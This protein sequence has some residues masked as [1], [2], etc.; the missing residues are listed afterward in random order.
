MPQIVVLP[1]EQHN[2]E[3]FPSIKLQSHSWPARILE[4]PLSEFFSQVPDDDWV[5]LINGRASLDAGMTASVEACIASGN[6]MSPPPAVIFADSMADGEL[7]I[8]P[9]FNSMTA[10]SLPSM[11]P[12]LA[13]RGDVARLL[14]DPD[15]APGSPPESDEFVWDLGL[16]AAD[17]AR[18]RTGS[19]RGT[20]HLPFVATAYETPESLAEDRVRALLERHRLRRER[21]DERKYT[22]LELRLH[23]R[24]AER[25][26]GRVTLPVHYVRPR[27]EQVSPLVSIIIPTIGTNRL[28]IQAIRSL[29]ATIHH[30]A[31]EVVLVTGPAMPSE[32]TDE[33]L[34]FDHVSA[35][36]VEGAFNF[37]ASVNTGVASSR[38]PV[39]LLLNDDV[40]A[41]NAGWLETLVAALNLPRV[42]VVGARLVL[43]DGHI[44]HAGI[45][46]RWDTGEPGHVGWGVPA[47]SALA[48]SLDSVL[49]AQVGTLGV[50]AACLA[51]TREVWDAVGGF[52]EELPGNYNDVVFASRVADLGLASVCCNQ[53]TLVHCESASRDA[54]VKQFEV[55]A[56]QKVLPFLRTDPFT[57]AWG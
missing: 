18:A 10:A 32:I 54:T 23:P 21:L 5:V 31:Y 35:V 14:A 26:D 55:D 47:D 27:N 44:Q 28:V 37:S 30:T 52:P 24:D 19:D 51:V 3:L 2:A 12:L 25:K 57:T 46:A 11:G 17:A 13:L 38:A 34:T 6:A 48:N 20:I 41:T 8:R 43:P 56:L 9:R 50:T 29:A 4:E 33:A 42:G 7:V 49:A 22:D 15:F 1:R 45:T 16:C 39:I 36:S 40:E 53:V